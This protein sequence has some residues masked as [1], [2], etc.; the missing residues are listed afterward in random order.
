MWPYSCQESNL[1]PYAFYH[2]PRHLRPHP[3]TEGVVWRI[4]YSWKLYVYVKNVYGEILGMIN[5]Q[6]SSLFSLGKSTWCLLGGITK[7]RTCMDIP[8]S[9]AMQDADPPPSHFLAYIEHN[10]VDGITGTTKGINDWCAPTLTR[11]QCCVLYSL[12]ILNNIS[13]TQFSHICRLY[14]ASWSTWS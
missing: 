9:H 2:V 10:I 1:S 12:E 6:A 4:P 13:S 5:S 14:V 8:C 11:I 3:Q 7:Y